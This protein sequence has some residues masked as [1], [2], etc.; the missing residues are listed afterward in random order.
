M[1]LTLSIRKYRAQIRAGN[2]KFQY[3]ECT[4]SVLQTRT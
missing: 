4:Y 3:L 2:P 1:T